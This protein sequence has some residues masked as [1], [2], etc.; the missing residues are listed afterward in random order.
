MQ[1]F[2]SSYSVVITTKDCPA[3]RVVAGIFT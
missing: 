2:F 3:R 1:L